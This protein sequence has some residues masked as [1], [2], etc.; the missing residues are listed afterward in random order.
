[1]YEISFRQLVLAI[2]IVFILTSLFID[3]QVWTWLLDSVRAY[4]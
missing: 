2:A 4:W 3:D 1:M